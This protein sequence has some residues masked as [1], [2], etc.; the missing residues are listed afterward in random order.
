MFTNAA[1][2][3]PIA[4]ALIGKGAALGTVLAF[5]SGAGI[6]AIATPSSASLQSLPC[7][8]CARPL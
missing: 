2:V 5:I 1:G 3:I 8:A 6:A 7:S 4:E